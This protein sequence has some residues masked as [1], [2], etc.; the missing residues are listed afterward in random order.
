MIDN[1][2]FSEEW[3][4]KEIIKTHIEESQT[5]KKTFLKISK[6]DLLRLVIK[7]IKL[8]KNT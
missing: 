7:F 6:I 2:E 5:G 8:N 3:L 4:T 1:I